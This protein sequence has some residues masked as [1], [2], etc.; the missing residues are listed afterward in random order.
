MK[1][2]IEFISYQGD[3]NVTGSKHFLKIGNQ[4][5]GLDYGIWQG[6]QELE[7]KNTN[8]KCPVP[9]DKITAM[10]LTHSHAD[11]CA[12]LPLLVKEGYKN[13]IYCTSA[14]RDL[15]H[16]V[17]M[18]SSDISKDYT[19]LDVIAAMDHFRSHSY[20]K[21]KHL[22][23][24]ISYTAYN[25]GH[26][27]GSAFMS[28]DLKPEQSFLEKLFKKD[29]GKV[30][31]LYTGDIGRDNNPIVN[32]PDSTS[33]PAPDYIIMEATYGNRLHEDLDYSLTNV[34]SVISETVG[35]GGKVLIPSFAIER[36]QELVYYLK[37]LMMKNKIP[38]VPVYLD[39]PMST[40][41]T[42]VFQIH[43][44]CFNSKIKG[45]FISKGK[46]PFSLSSLKIIK[47]SQESKKLVKSKKPCIIIAGNG[48][49]TAGRILTHLQQGLSNPLNTVLL[50]GY[51]SERS[52]ARELLEGA[53][54]VNINNKEV[55]VKANIVSTCAFS[56]HADY[57][58]MTEWLKSIDTHNLKKIFL[59]HGNL[60]AK[61]FFK[62]HLEENGFRDIVITEENKNYKLI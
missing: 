56:A 61:K 5:L 50:V 9:V 22:N 43:P 35:K 52:L 4:Y 41:A 23:D 39:S 42:G 47:D 40:T 21:T 44:E 57:G 54:Y 45:Q 8:Y 55:F 53:S 51:S 60:E 37:V 59:V 30:N 48:M 17:L 14:T 12:L 28:I 10:L 62:K 58:E 26:I 24:Q 16:V 18:N 15:A 20:G 46:N 6:N 33:I 19:E 29:K 27:L 11:H 49:C 25:A 38:K 32:K 34:A 13:N 31:V 3:D 2:S 36:A 1:K 7:G